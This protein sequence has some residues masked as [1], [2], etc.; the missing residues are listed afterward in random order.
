M[1]LEWHGDVD[2]ADGKLQSQYQAYRDRLRFVGGICRNLLNAAQ[3]HQTLLDLKH[4]DQDIVADLT[5]ISSA[6]QT[7][8]DDYSTKLASGSS[9]E[10]NL[11]NLGWTVDELSRLNKS[12]RTVLVEIR[13]LIELLET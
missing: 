1:R 6:L 2:L 12:G 5:F 3:K 10:K 4:A 9:T 13:A 7:A 8:N 11:F